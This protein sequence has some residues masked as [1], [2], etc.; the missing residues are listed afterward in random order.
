MNNIY[1]IGTTKRSHQRQQDYAPYWIEWHILL[2]R[3][4]D[5]VPRAA[6]NAAKQKLRDKRRSHKLP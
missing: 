6:S 5:Y 3:N 1:L 4:R 2:Q